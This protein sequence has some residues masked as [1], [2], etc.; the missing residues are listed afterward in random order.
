MLPPLGWI[1]RI[2]ERLNVRGLWGRFHVFVSCICLTEQ[3]GQ[4]V[5]F[6]VVV[7][8]LQCLAFQ[9]LGGGM[10]VSR[11]EVFHGVVEQHLTD[12]VVNAQIGPRCTG[13][14][15]Q[16]MAGPFTPGQTREQGAGQRCADGCTGA[17]REQKRPLISARKSVM[18]FGGLAKSGTELR[19]AGRSLT[20]KGTSHG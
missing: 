13:H 7:P 12:H 4:P 2:A 10:D 1:L 8:R 11:V 18:E 6:E 15:A 14:F 5:L 20:W 17:A 9:A 19:M 16:V 3:R